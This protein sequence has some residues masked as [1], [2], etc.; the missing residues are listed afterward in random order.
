VAFRKGK[1][2]GDHPPT[3]NSGGRRHPPELTDR[4]RHDVYA[5]AHGGRD[6]R[7]VLGLVGEAG[8]QHEREL[9]AVAHARPL[10]RDGAGR[11]DQLHEDAVDGADEESGRERIAA[12]AEPKASIGR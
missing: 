6:E 8:D 2:L 1:S 7:V 9:R 5:A 12:G 4:A 10:V 3:H 11:L